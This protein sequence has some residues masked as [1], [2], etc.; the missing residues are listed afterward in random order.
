MNQVYAK[1]RLRGRTNKYRKVLSTE[2]GIYLSPKELIESSYSYLPDTKLDED[3]WF[4]IPEFSQKE[5]SIEITKADYESVDYDSLRKFEYEQLDFLFT[6]VGKDFFFQN[7][8]KSRLIKRKGILAFGERYRYQ[9]DMSVL[10][11]NEYPDAIY[12][13]AE[14]TLYFQRLE[15]IINIFKGISELYREATE[16]EVKEF[17][18]N[19]F[20]IL[21]DGFDA[22]KVKRSNR[23]RIALAINTLAKMQNE[24]KRQIF[25]YIREYCPDIT[26]MEQKF[27]IG[28]EE[29][30]RML[31]YGIEQRFY[32]TLVGSEKRIANSIVSL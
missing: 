14:D 7:I 22:S 17:L 1:I 20:I 10:F 18:Q 30:L 5:F 3:E 15:P 16:S 29:G 23:K 4:K 24:D 26:T 27:K 21:A 31:L 19:D 25:T 6:K 32:T 8:G 12:V 28:S 9:N 13:P 11:I 2:E